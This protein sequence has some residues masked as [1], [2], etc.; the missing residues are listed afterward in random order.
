MN[1]MSTKTGSMEQLFTQCLHKGLFS[2]QIR[3]I[4]ALAVTVAEQIL[5]ARVVSQ[6]YG[7]ES[8]HA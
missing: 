7:I 5:R 1:T 2:V 3:W 6:A 8:V 4:W